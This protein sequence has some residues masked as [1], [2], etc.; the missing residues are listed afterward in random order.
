MSAYIYNYSITWRMTLEEPK[1][2]ATN[3]LTNSMR[4]Q[5]MPISTIPFL[6]RTDSEKEHSVTHKLAKSKSGKVVRLGYDYVESI[7]TIKALC[8]FAAMHCIKNTKSLRRMI[9]IRCVLHK[10]CNLQALPTTLCSSR[11]SLTQHVTHH[12]LTPSHSML[13]YNLTRLADVSKTE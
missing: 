7:H 1:Q 2:S 9:I 8:Y 5:I 3:K 11:H 12:A 10:L 13:L 4:I 6:E